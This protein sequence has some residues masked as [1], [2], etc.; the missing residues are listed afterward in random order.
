MTLAL[1]CGFG[2]REVATL[3]FAEVIHGK[4]HSFIKRHRG[5]PGVYAEWVLWPETVEALAYLEQFRPEGAAFVV[6]DRD[7][8]P[9]T[10][11]MK[12]DNKNDTIARHWKRMLGRVEA[13]CPGFHKLSFKH[14]RK[15]GASMVRHLHVENAAELSTMYLAHGE[16]ADSRDSL[17]PVYTSRPWKKLHR[18]L[19]KLR[20]KLLPVVGRV[21][22]VR[23][24]RVPRGQRSAPR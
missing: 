5:K 24:R 8:K 10:E 4:K 1:N 19:L 15:T 6:A 18:A 16:T 12:S 3:Q 17:L 23:C 2:N 13:D 20:K 14:L 22:P 7:G 9:L 11:R 21:T